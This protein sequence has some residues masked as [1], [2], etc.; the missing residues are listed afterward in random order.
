VEQVLSYQSRLAGLPH[1]ERPQER[2]ERFGAEAL[3][4]T[5]LLAMLLRKGTRSRDVLA[6][7]DELMLKGGS[8]S[9]LL[10]LDAA[11]LLKVHG[12]GR[13]KA[14]QIAAV[15]EMARRA[16]LQRAE[17][18]PVFDRPELVYQFF[19]PIVVGLEVE[20]FWVLC[21]NRKNRLIRRCEVTKGTA[22]A[23]LIHP[24]EFFRAG[25]QNGASALIAVHNHPSG[26]PS[27]SSAD[28]QV[29]RRLRESA[30]ILDIDLLDHVIVGRSS[31]DAHGLG[32]YSFSEAGLL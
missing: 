7:A 22:S 3:S 2:M 31:A 32:F 11:D 25:V 20:Y 5:E 14:L 15:L 13:V 21:L 17:E 26:D 12:I 16:I 30:A 27:P 18:Q 1:G 8:L 9:G 4:D 10:A 29:T 6:V 24:R 23:S 19:Q 28:I